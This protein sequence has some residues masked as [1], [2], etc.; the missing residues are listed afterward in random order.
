MF[1]HILGI[2]PFLIFASFLFFA[3]PAGAQETAPAP[4]DNKAS[5]SLID[6]PAAK[7]HFKIA[8][9]KFCAFAVLQL[10]ATIADFETTQWA[11]RKAPFGAER[12]P[13]FG[14]HPSRGRMYSI[15]FSI[16][17]LQIFMQY[18]SK[19]FGERTGKLKHAWLAGALLDTGLHTFLAVHNAKIA[20]RGN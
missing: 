14:S 20:A 1:K 11:E 3:A 6:P 12:N 7:R 17:S 19:R 4:A 16:T 8:D 10:G 2:L 9:K 5:L 18:R 13:L 15:G